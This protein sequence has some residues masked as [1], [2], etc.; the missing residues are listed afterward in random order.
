MSLAYRCIVGTSLLSASL[1]LFFGYPPC[2]DFGVH[3]A[4]VSMLAGLGELER[5]PRNIYEYNLGHP[6]QMIHLLALPIALILRSTIALKTVLALAVALLPLAAAHFARYVR[7]SVWLA[8]FSVPIAFGWLFYWGFINNILGLAALLW[9]LPALDRAILEPS[10]RHIAASFSWLLVLYLSHELM[11]LAFVG[12]ALFFGVLQI[13]TPRNA[14]VGVLLGSLGA[15]LAAAQLVVQEPLRTATTTLST[16]DII[17][18]PLQAKVIL[19]PE[20]LFGLDSFGARILL[21]ISCLLVGWHAWTSR[22]THEPRAPDDSADSVPLWI[23]RWRFAILGFLSL[24]VYLVAPVA[25][26]GAQLVSPRYLAPGFAL[27][28]LSVGGSLAQPPRI[29]CLAVCAVPIAG[30]LRAIPEFLASTQSMAQLET[31]SARIP[32]GSSLVGLN[33]DDHS[34]A[35]NA[36]HFPAH[37][38]AQRGGRLAVSFAESTVAPVHYK[39]S[40]QWNEPAARLLREPR[41]FMPTYDFTRFGYAILHSSEPTEL[42]LAIAAMEPEGRLI[43]RRGEWALLASTLSVDPISGPDRPLPR[44]IPETL[45]SRRAKLVRRL[46]DDPYFALPDLPSTP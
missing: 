15:G 16:S 7:G 2:T 19:A 20:L 37:V 23:F 8:L 4:L 28:T 18:W 25:L 3:E 40:A 38:L 46:R 32:L 42:R 45:A 5:W 30:W 24:V 43:L 1:V 41:H 35:W 9:A 22:R 12:A 44:P 31:L 33:L 36:D 34:S 29:F 26:N 27:L 11:M 21:C 39:L 10:G 6:N 14:M 13:R 17:F